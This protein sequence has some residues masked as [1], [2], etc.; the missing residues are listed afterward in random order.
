MLPA[1]SLSQK[2]CIKRS[3]VLAVAAG[4]LGV[5]DYDAAAA[6]TSLNSSPRPDI[7]LG[8]FEGKVLDNWTGTGTAFDLIPLQPGAGGLVAPKQRDGGRVTNFEG[9]GVVWS[10]RGGLTNQGTLLS[11]EFVIQRNYLNYL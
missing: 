1:M 4:C 2:Q 8:T 6:S 9:A 7:V 3:L 10:G 11:P 5:P